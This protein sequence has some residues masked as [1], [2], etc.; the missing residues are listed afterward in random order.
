MAPHAER[1]DS[2][3]TTTMASTDSML[4]KQVNPASY[5]INKKVVPKQVRGSI[6]FSSATF[7]L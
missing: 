5:K 7:S 6:L 4:K 1:T 3:N 2:L